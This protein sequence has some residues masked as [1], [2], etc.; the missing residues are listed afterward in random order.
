MKS[1]EVVANE[2]RSIRSW[3]LRLNGGAQVVAVERTSDPVKVAVRLKPTDPEPVEALAYRHVTVDVG[4]RVDLDGSESAGLR[5]RGSVAAATWHT[6]TYENSWAAYTTDSYAG[7]R[8]RYEP[9][10]VVRLDGAVTGG[11]LAAVIFTLPEAARPASRVTLT[12]VSNNAFCRVDVAPDGSV[13]HVTGGSNAW[14][15]ICASFP[16]G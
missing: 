14:V 15:A 11:T 13:S 5:V 6:P 10:R 7:L 9:G 4:D 3:A 2:V 1:L 16:I 12:A 8:W